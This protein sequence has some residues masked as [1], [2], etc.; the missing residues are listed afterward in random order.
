LRETKTDV[1]KLLDS[2]K[3]DEASFSVDYLNC[4]FTEVVQRPDGTTET[5]YRRYTVRRNAVTVSMRAVVVIA[6][7]IG[8]LMLKPAMLGS[9][10]NVVTTLFS[11]G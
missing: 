9:I 7:V 2:M 8:A 1:A 6:L 4:D 5:R 3:D 10:R 11:S